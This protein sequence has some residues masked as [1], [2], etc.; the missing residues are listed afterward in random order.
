MRAVREND[1]QRAKA[2]Q[3]EVRASSAATIRMLECYA[4]GFERRSGDVFDNARDYVPI[5]VSVSIE[6]D[7]RNRERHGDSLL[8]TSI[9]KGMIRVAPATAHDGKAAD[10]SRAVG[11]YQASVAHAL[12]HLRYSRP[13]SPISS[14]GALRIA[15][16][17]LIEDARVE[18][19]LMREY[20]GLRD[21]WGAFHTASGEHGALTFASLAARLARAL[22]DPRYDDPNDWIRKGRELFDALAERPADI[23]ACKE[24]ADILAVDLAQMRVRFDASSYRV[25]PCYRD[26]NTYL[27]AIESEPVRARMEQVPDAVEDTTARS[28]MTDGPATQD[29]APDETGVLRACRYPEWHARIGLLLDDWT[30]VYDRERIVDSVHDSQGT[31]RNRSASRYPP[32]FWWQQPAARIRRRFEG[33][34]FDLD[35]VV[36]HGIARRTGVASDG[37]IFEQRR[38]TPQGMSVLLLLD[39]SASTNERIGQHGTTVLDVEKEAAATVTCALESTVTRIAVQGFA[40]NGRHDVRYV[41]IKDFDEP[42][43]EAQRKR[44]RAQEGAFSTRMGA[45]LRHAAALLS[46][47]CSEAK[48]LVLV[49]DG[50]PSD[51]DVFDSYHLIEDARHA[52][53]ALSSRGIVPFC[54]AFDRDADR[55][56]RTI[57]GANRYLVL[58][59]AENLAAQIGKVL[60]GAR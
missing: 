10:E 11:L 26:D 51:V 48:W 47:E 6:A 25:E 22:H 8:R 60:S 20:P 14:R 15:V 5:R 30:C 38:R 21:L 56:V 50:E 29:D 39:L 2:P 49:T 52:V 42:F 31:R 58:D 4:A 9:S 37:R 12:A 43:G 41:R 27:W 35:A 45:A 16:A 1:E 53:S 23:A 18:R 36:E 32:P 13:A 17:S 54:F 24:V 59:G 40:S 3:D 57:F 55:Y 46:N 7:E 34:E 33:D 19:L 28:N 44:L